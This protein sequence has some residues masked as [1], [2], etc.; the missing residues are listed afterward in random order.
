MNHGSMKLLIDAHL[1]IAWNA[2]SYD[3][4]QLL[5]I[6]DLRAGESHLSGKSR[7]NCTVSL[8]EMRNGGIGLCL[9]TI[10]SRALP[11]HQ[12]TTVGHQMTK[13]VRDH[14][15][16]IGERLRN[17]IILRENL[18]YANQTIA[19]AAAQGQLAYYQLLE[20]AGQL[21]MIRT[22]AELDELWLGWSNKVDGTPIGFI[23]SMEGTDPI[24]DP[25]QA[26]FWW[27]KGLRTACLA[28][29]GPST[30]AM[31]TGGDGPLTNKGREL[32][33]IFNQLGMILDL[34]HTADTA[35]EQ[36]LDIFQ[37]PVFV[38]HGNCRT[39]V[40]HDR[41]I[42]N[43]QIQKI[44]ERGGV[45]GVVFDCWMLS[46]KWRK[47]TPGNPRPSLTTVV[48]HID[49]ICQIAGSCQ[50]VGIGSDLDGGFGTEQSPKELE[51]IADL[52]KLEPLLAHRG[53]S[54]TDINAIFHEN[55]LR[56]FRDALP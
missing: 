18:D 6:Q 12:N 30:H 20:T 1:D 52:Q 48:D 41:Q 38:S 26:Q 11:C 47:G 46:S 15:G 33:A 53:Y 9:A 40:P 10:L 28:H 39:L 31:G 29:Y 25:A 43:D 42:S 5:S 24:V 49:H 34:V 45:I 4:D 44:T 19:C 23:L 27:D 36:A 2:L 32:L 50:H 17:E 56:F 35:L 21:K 54:N 22:A 14:L 51:T 55:W 7:G 37:G 8:P 16:P 3:R 13:Q